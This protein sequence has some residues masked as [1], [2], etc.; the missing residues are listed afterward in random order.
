MHLR[1]IVFWNTPGSGSMRQVQKSPRM[2]NPVGTSHH[3]KDFVVG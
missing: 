3:R 2:P 1:R